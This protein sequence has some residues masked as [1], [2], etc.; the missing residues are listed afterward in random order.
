MSVVIHHNPDCG[1]SRN[2]LAIIIAS[3]VEPVVIPYLDT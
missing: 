3:G 2:V 1:T